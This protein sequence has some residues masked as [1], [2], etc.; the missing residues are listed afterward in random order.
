V[1]S[2]DNEHAHPKKHKHGQQGT[3]AL[4]HPSY[5][6]IIKLL[7]IKYKIYIFYIYICIKLLNIKYKN[8]IF[9]IYIYIKVEENNI[10]ELSETETAMFRCPKT[11]VE[12]IFSSILRRS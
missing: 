11:M 7:N 6:L 3:Q 9:Y 5:F 10:F 4:G 8:Y 1:P 2:A 12:E